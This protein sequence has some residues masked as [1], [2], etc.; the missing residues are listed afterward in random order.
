METNR[1]SALVIHLPTAAPSLVANPPKRR[2]RYPR[3]VLT[4]WEIECR[5][6]QKRQNRNEIAE[7]DRVAI[8]FERSAAEARYMAAQRRQRGES[9]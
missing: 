8:V 5:A 1:A 9:V 7:L 6:R 2:G 4:F 3:C